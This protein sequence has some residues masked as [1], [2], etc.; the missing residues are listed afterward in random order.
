VVY[1]LYITGFSS[2]LFMTRMHERYLEYTLPFL[3]LIS[4][5]DKRMLYG[6]IFLSLFSFLN[7]YHNWWAPRI[8]P[9][10]NLLSSVDFVNLLTI[11]AITFY[12]YSLYRF[13]NK[14]GV[15][16]Q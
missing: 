3:L 7:L 9:L 11:I 6:F 4:I 5:K 1:A 10:V 12:A 16:E 8:N 15:Y 2:F 14:N 13:F